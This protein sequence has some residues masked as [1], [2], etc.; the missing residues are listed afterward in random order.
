MKRNAIPKQ[1]GVFKRVMK[2]LFRY[3]PVMT[4]VTIFCLIV[5]AVISSIPAIFMQ[6]I[7]SVL[8]EA[9][10][11]ALHGGAALG[12]AEVGG[13]VTKYMLVL[14]G[15]Y[16]VSLSFGAIH[17]QLLA[18]ITQGFLRKIREQMFNG[19]QDLPVR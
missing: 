9:L 7:F 13:V 10:N 8:E 19:M 11:P 17:A 6:N 3:Y 2:A 15:M 14:I 16:V 12:W 1:K 18:I 4:T 5:N